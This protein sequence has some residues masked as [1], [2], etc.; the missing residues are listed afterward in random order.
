MFLG[1]IKFDVVLMCQM[2]SCFFELLG[3][4]ALCLR[5]F[6]VVYKLYCVAVVSVVFVSSCLLCF[7]CFSSRLVVVGGSRL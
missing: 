5:C 6:W 4:F 7:H 1:R 2:L 3:S